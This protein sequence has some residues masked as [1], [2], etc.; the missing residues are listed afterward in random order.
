LGVFLA[1]VS[2][3]SGHY[4]EQLGHHGRDALEVPGS[5]ITAQP[6]RRS[7]HDD[8]GLLGSGIHLF[9]RRS[10]HQVDL[11]TNTT[12]HLVEDA[13]ALREHLNIERWL[14]LG[15]SWGSTLAL[16]YAEVHPE[17]VTEMVLFGV[18]TGRRSEFDW[19]FRGGVAAF[20][21]EAWERLK[22]AAGG[23]DDADVVQRYTRL[24]SDPDPAVRERAAY[25]WC[26]WESATPAWPPA[27]GLDDRFS[28]PAYALAFARIVTHYVRHDAWV[29]DGSLLRGASALAEIPGL[30]VNGRLD[31]QSPLRNAWK[32]QRAWPRAEL[33][34]VDEAGHRVT[35]PLTR[36]I[37]RATD[38]FAR[39]AVR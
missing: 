8:L 37:V 4:V 20:F 14:V 34:I 29:G 15:G 30:L 27:R 16:A 24:L 19:L 35:P 25:E 36:E 23:T 12:W 3:V 18:T 38:R 17:R 26:L 9:D 28:D 1:E 7:F 21:P 13:E 2:P 5:K 10:E 6:A 22:S 39:D 33:V 31:F 11:A 32:L